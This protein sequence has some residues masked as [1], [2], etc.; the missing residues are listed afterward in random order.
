MRSVTNGKAHGKGGPMVNARGCV[1]GGMQG[2]TTTH[3]NPL[4]THLLVM[5]TLKTNMYDNNVVIYSSD[6]SYNLRF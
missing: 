6:T 2:T 3:S 4:S 5:F 1:Y